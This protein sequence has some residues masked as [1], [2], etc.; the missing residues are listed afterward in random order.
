ME[1]LFFSCFSYDFWISEGDVD[2]GYPNRFKI[3]FV[4]SCLLVTGIFLNTR[5]DPPTVVKT[6]TLLKSFTSFGSWRVLDDI[7]LDK[8]IQD[9]LL[10]DDYLYRRYTDGSNAVNLYIGYYYTSSKVGAAHDP[11]VC[12]PGQGRVISNHESG[13]INLALD[14]K[15]LSVDYATMQTELSGQKDAL[16]YWFQAQDKTASN[17]LKQKVMLLWGRISTGR[18]ENAFVRISMDTQG[19]AYKQCFLILNGF[20]ES[21]YPD[22]YQYVQSAQRQN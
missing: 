20:V 22:F 16:L 8:N 3:I 6:D 12:Y 21:F 5:S 4:V 15:E 18:E 9:E 7:P 14:D 11:L 13:S 10:L 2:M 19:K 17:T 1:S